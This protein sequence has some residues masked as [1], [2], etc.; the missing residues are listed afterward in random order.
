MGQVAVISTASYLND[1]IAQHFAGSA[2][3][4]AP[5]FLTDERRVLEFLNYELPELSIINLGD[6]DLAIDEIVRAIQSDPWLHYG[7]LIC[8]HPEP[9]PK[10]WEERLTSS[11]V[12]SFI[13][14]HELDFS[15]PRVIR[16]LGNNRQF[17]FQREIQD[18]LLNRIAGT[19]VIDNDPLDIRTYSHL[20]TW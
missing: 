15:L 14:Q 5:E 9:N 7:G 8:V 16:I 1:R 18:R 6:S 4:F 12:V 2:S 10:Q 13:P 20:L 11:N 17:L 3:T 19:F